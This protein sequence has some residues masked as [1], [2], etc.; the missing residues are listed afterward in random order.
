MKCVSPEDKNG[1]GVINVTS[2]LSVRCS[3]DT[4]QS[5]YNETALIISMSILG[6][7]L[8]LG[9]I[10]YLAYKLKRNNVVDSNDF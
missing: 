2:D 5:T 9:G 4:P 6:G 7:L 3:S 10:G 8:L 1:E